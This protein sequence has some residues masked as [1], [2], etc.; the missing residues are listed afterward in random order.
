[1]TDDV[2]LDYADMAREDLSRFNASVQDLLCG[3][4]GNENAVGSGIKHW[5]KRF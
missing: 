2:F 5:M 1:M 4:S 3:A